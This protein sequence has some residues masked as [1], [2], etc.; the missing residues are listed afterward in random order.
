MPEYQAL[1]VE[2]EALQASAENEIVVD[3]K[4]L[5]KP[6]ETSPELPKLLPLIARESR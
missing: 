4:L 1:R 3:P 2:L 6:G 5:L